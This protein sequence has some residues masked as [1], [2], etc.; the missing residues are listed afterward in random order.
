[1]A[2][3]SLR[4]RLR[5]AALTYLVIFFVG[6]IA[7]VAS[8]TSW[9]RELDER[10]DLLRMARLAAEL[11]GTYPGQLY[12]VRGYARSGDQDL[13]DLYTDSAAESRSTTAE[14]AAVV[15]KRPTLATAF[16]DMVDAADRWTL[17]VAEP[18]IAARDVGDDATVGARL[19]A[20]DADGEQFN[21]LQARIT[22]FADSID[23]RA[24]TVGERAEFERQ[25]LV[26]IIAA[27]LVTLLAF[28]GLLA[29]LT[30]RWIIR[31][32]RQ[33]ADAT[34]QVLAGE[35]VR[36][37]V[38]GP[39]EL[40]EVAQAVDDMQRTIIEQRD[41]AVRARESVEQNALL[42]V[43]M[44]TEL[45]S[46]MGEY[47]A[48]WSVSTSLRAA[49]GL[50][51]GDSYDVSLLSPDEISVVVLDIAGHG[52]LAA[53]SAFKCKELIKAALRS[54]YSPGESLMWLTDQELGLGNSFFTAV[55]AIVDTSSAVCQYANAGHPPPVLI[56]E[57]GTVQLL[58]PTGPLFGLVEPGWTTRE[59]KIAR[60]A[61]LTIFTDGLIEAR[62]DDGVFY[63]EERLAAL[64]AQMGECDADNIMKRLLEDLA[65]FQPGR[66]AD[67]VTVAVVCHA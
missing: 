24:A 27:K 14:L 62:S 18:L 30:Q 43:Q 48:G 67:D 1:M 17:E 47:P 59:C 39:I 13:R 37:A 46:S 28:T 63:G 6:A 2:E 26:I 22:A 55:V 51:A 4:S 21:A 35:H 45:A 5:L 56:G 42:A 57:D 3:V 9:S 29:W 53:I 58:E 15:A 19:A 54:G 11:D 41:E 36:V 61:S 31:P 20:D 16:T 23:R 33:I 60:G 65:A 50:V 7:I 25:R 64:L 10:R 52:A 66:V 40:V 12:G 32:T 44:R 8:L 49:E 34:K 38:E